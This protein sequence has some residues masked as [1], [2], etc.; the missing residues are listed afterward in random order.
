MNNEFDLKL[1]S[2]AASTNF[3]VD[4]YSETSATDQYQRIYQNLGTTTTE[5]LSDNN[6]LKVVFSLITE[7]IPSN[8]IKSVIPPGQGLL[9]STAEK[10]RL[11]RNHRFY[12]MLADRIDRNEQPNVFIK[13]IKQNPTLATDL[14]MFMKEENQKI[15]SEEKRARFAN[16]IYKISS[17]ENI[18][19]EEAK[20]YAKL[21]MQFEDYDIAIL[22]Y[23][24][25]IPNCNDGLFDGIPV[26]TLLSKPQRENGPVIIQNR[27]PTLKPYVAFKGCSRLVSEG[28]LADEGVGR[29]GTKTME[30]F[31]ITEAGR[32]FLNWISE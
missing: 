1:S 10:I 2:S 20:E 26:I 16:I 14:F 31:R 11:D 17:D 8:S 18:S 15:Q 27:F 32:E 21:V 23:A 13:N 4:M 25:K 3:A 29:I 19:I 28:L 12:Q 30:Y 7:L 24:A 5:F 9:Q 6:P 22:S